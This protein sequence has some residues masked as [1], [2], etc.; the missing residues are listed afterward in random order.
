VEKQQTTIVLPK[1]VR[2]RFVRI[3][4]ESNEFLTVGEVEV[5]STRKWH[6]SPRDTVCCRVHRCEPSVCPAVPHRLPVRRVVW[7]RLPHRTDCIHSG[8]QHAEHLQVPRREGV[9]A[10]SHCGRGCVVLWGQSLVHTPSHSCSRA[11]ALARLQGRLRA[12]PVGAHHPGL[13]QANGRGAGH[14]AHPD[15]CSR[16]RRHLQLEHLV[17]RTCRAVGVVGVRCR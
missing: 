6:A 12:R 2:G 7:R 10:A 5:F 9:Q 1:I 17:Q 14:V 8:V 3:Q 4:L 13:V 15:V 16:R 11:R